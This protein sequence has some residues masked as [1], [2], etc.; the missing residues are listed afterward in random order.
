[1]KRYINKKLI[2]IVLG[3]V[4]FSSC[5][6]L[7]NSITYPVYTNIE[8]WSMPDTVAVNSSFNVYVS[9]SIDNTCLKNMYF[10][11]SKSV[12]E[13]NYLIW[14]TATFENHGE[15]CNELKVPFDSTFHITI[16]AVGK[17]YFYFKYDNSSKKD[18]IFIKP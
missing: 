13:K 16:T 3:I 12:D 6:D 8:Y 14:P 10:T 17:Y 18:S 2:F 4:S 7:E 1:M 5:G 9:S 15:I 11:M